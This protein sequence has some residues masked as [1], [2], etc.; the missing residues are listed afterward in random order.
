MPKFCYGFYSD[1]WKPNLEFKFYKS[2]KQGDP[3]SPFLFILIMESLHLSFKNVV[4]V[5]LYKGLPVDGSLIL[6]HL[7]Y[8]DDVVFVGKWDKQN[9]ATI[10]NVL[11]CF[12]LASGLKINL[13]KSKLMGTGTPHENVL[14]ASESIGCSTF[15]APFNFLG[16]KVET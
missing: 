6:S 14:S 11:N 2:L 16:I 12:I 3:L 15:A 7:F 5:G 9:V 10:V 8:A 1:Q 4:H 13:P